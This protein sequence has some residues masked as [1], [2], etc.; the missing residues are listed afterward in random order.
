[1]TAANA[2]PIFD[3]L[4]QAVINIVSVY[5]LDMDTTVFPLENDAWVKVTPDCFYWC[6]TRLSWD[7]P[8][9]HVEEMSVLAHQIFMV[10]K[11]MTV[12]ASIAQQNGSHLVAEVFDPNI[13]AVER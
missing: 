5:T 7:F 2:I 10:D 4:P 1:M 11:Y 12:R 6:L 8:T 9:Y 3:S 13:M